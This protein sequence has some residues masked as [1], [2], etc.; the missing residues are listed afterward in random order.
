M[1]VCNFSLDI[2]VVFSN[3]YYI[4]IYTDF[5]CF[6]VKVLCICVSWCAN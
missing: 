4:Y 2:P 5:K 6:N 1:R 3:Q